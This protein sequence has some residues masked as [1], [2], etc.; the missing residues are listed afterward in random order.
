MLLL[1]TMPK[2]ERSTDVQKSR[3]D[4]AQRYGRAE[5]GSSELLVTKGIGHSATLTSPPFRDRVE[6]SRVLGVWDRDE[7]GFPPVLSP[8]MAPSTPS[9]PSS[10]LFR[11]ED[12]KS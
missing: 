2:G 7:Q 9:T 10:Q 6:K 12:R 4:S 1:G 8:R 11:E 3:S 5:V